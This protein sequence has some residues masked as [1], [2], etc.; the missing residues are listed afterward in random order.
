MSFDQKFFLF[1]TQKKRRNI[2]GEHQFAPFECDVIFP[3][4]SQF[5]KW[6]ELWSSLIFAQNR[7]A[8]SE[9]NNCEFAYAL[10]SSS[11]AQSISH[12]R[13]MFGYK[14]LPEIEFDQQ[15]DS[16][17]LLARDLHENEKPYFPVDRSNSLV[18]SVQTIPLTVKMHD[19]EHWFEHCQGR[20]G[21]KER[22]KNMEILLVAISACSSHLDEIQD[23][24]SYQTKSRVNIINN[25]KF[26]IWRLMISISIGRNLSILCSERLSRSLFFHVSEPLNSVKTSRDDS[27]SLLI[28]PINMRNI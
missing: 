17:A 28:S 10:R 15:I 8:I 1:I 13:Y 6:N 20:F 22:H 4:H 16:H 25:Y 14:L 27:R 2:A 21:H 26:L 9:M 18:F 12:T 5:L 23:Y 24:F 11:R 7:E 3:S 19:T